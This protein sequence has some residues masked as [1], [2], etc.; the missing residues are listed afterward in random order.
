MGPRSHKI[1]KLNNVVFV[2]G[3]LLAAA[4]GEYPIRSQEGEMAARPLNNGGDEIPACKSIWEQ[5]QNLF[6]FIILY[7]FWGP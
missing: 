4:G 2:P 7:V 6:N 5:T 1:I 3:R